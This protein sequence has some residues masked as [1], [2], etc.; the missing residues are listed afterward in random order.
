MLWRLVVC[1]FFRFILNCLCWGICVDCLELGIW[2][3]DRRLHVQLHYRAG[4]RVRSIFFSNQR[5]PC[6]D[7]FS[8][9]HMDVPASIDLWDAGVL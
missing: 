5:R 8:H 1:V 2:S 6:C 4:S 3:A 7:G 9:V